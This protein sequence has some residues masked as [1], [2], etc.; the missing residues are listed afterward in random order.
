MRGAGRTAVTYLKGAAVAL[1]LTCAASGTALA[2]GVSAMDDGIVAKAVRTLQSDL[3]VASL[4]CGGRDA[5]NAFMQTYDP[6]L[7]GNNRRL[8][9][10]F[11]DRHGGGH[12]MALNTYLT[13]IANQGALRMALTGNRFCTRSEVLHERLAETPSD[14]RLRMVAIAYAASAVP[15][16]AEEL[17]EG[18]SQQGCTAYKVAFESDLKEIVQE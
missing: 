1:G 6:H 17:D 4:Q 2:C 7:V 3:M 13:S 15:Y 11:V 10:H 9:Q 5:Y 12:K 16:L 18:A 14:G 8:K